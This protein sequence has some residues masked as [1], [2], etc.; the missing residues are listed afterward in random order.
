MDMYWIEQI[1]SEYLTKFFLLFP[2]FT[3]IHFYI[4]FIAIGYW[5]RPG[6]K[7]FA[8]LGFLIPFATI[9][10]AILN[11]SLQIVRPPVELQ[12]IDYGTAFGFPNSEI[13]VAVVFWGVLMHRSKHFLTTL[14]PLFFLICIGFSYIYLGS[15]TVES[16]I[17]GFYLGLLL[18]GFWYRLDVQEEINNWFSYDTRSFWGIY[19][20]CFATYFASYEN[21][22]F[23]LEVAISLG[24]LVGYGLSITSMR[25]WQT[26]Q[27][28][29]SV[30][31]FRIVILCYVMLLLIS[32]TL[33]MIEV[34]E[35]TMLAST[36][37]E[38]AILSVLI[39]A[40]C[41]RIIKNEIKRFGTKKSS[42]IEHDPGHDM[43]VN[44]KS[45][46]G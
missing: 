19:L 31:H 38:F 26:I 36:M 17:A 8:H 43:V 45:L 21:D 32:Y 6:G 33:P 22:I 16:T 25:K 42:N 15:Y 24:A 39:F 27:N 28:T 9:I 23:I 34:T 13:F 41:P 5:L 29:Y 40:L 12:L 35:G 46:T 44:Y 11:N 1:R 4:S 10:S 14:I 30:V 20:L 18:L 2:F 7:T 3:S 37:V